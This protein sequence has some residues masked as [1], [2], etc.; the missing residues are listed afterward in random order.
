MAG[1]IKEKLLQARAL[2]DTALAE[3]NEAP[4]PEPVEPEPDP[5]PDPDPEPG[6]TIDEG[7]LLQFADVTVNGLI[8][9]SQPF[10]FDG[11]ARDL[12]VIGKC[13]LAG[14]SGEC[15]VLSIENEAGSQYHQIGIGYNFSSSSVAAGRVSLRGKGTS[16]YTT[17]GVGGL[18]F[19][20]SPI[21]FLLHYDTD[22]GYLNLWLR[23][24]PDRWKWADSV[25]SARFE[26]ARLRFYNRTNG[27]AS[28]QSVFSEVTANR[29]WG[30][31]IG[32]S[33]TAGH[34]AFDPDGSYYSGRDNGL[35]QWQ[36]HCWPFP[37]L[38]NSIIVNKGIGGTT[39]TETRN[40]ISE[41]HKHEN[42]VVFL[43]VQNNDA[44]KG[45]S[46]DQRTENI[47]ASIDAC[48]AAG[49]IVILYGAI[50]HNDKPAASAYYKQWRDEQLPL[51]VGHSGY[52]E[53]MEPLADP[54]S[55]DIQAQYTT[56]GTHP[57]V[58]GYTLIGQHIQ[59]SIAQILQ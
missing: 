7:I 21:E 1:T 24:G 48:V 35:S 13:Q 15:A 19:V 8:Q 43:S 49:C 25:R 11:S 22:R 39:T 26:V 55:G 3:M 16:T 54:I 33:I 58:A 23:D 31:S 5:E 44:V 50:Y 53:V 29:P 12:I 59:S 32:N 9:E 37:G 46:L 18:E 4:A 27:P 20:A 51:L 41:A 45:V 36:A 14:V 2:I 10:V 34:N 40:R 17:S 47:Q 42:P 57:N 52:V 38:R 56:D 28:Q 6:L 30:V